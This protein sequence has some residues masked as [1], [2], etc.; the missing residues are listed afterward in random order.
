MEQ[1]RVVEDGPPADLIAD[2]TG[3]FSGLHQAWADSLV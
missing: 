3:R 2:G 1:G